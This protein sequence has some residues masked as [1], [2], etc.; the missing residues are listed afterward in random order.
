MP[1][2]GRLLFPP[3]HPPIN[4]G[5]LSP[6]LDSE[7]DIPCSQRRDFRFARDVPRLRTLDHRRP[8]GPPL[9]EETI[10]QFY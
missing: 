9:G 8:T 4:A 6:N 7:H 1:L 5:E 2:R 3:S 10:C